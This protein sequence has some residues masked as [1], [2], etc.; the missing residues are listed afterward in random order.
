MV[1]AGVVLDGGRILYVGFMCHQAVEKMLKAYHTSI[2]DDSPPYIHGLLK[3]AKVSGIYYDMNED[4]KDILDILDPLNIEARY[5]SYKEEL[6]KSLSPEKC[7]DI[8]KRT[9]ELLS[10]IKKKS[11]L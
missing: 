7:E 10:W 6:M 9:G 4:F 2:R 11:S 1:T 8:I 3:L 5:P